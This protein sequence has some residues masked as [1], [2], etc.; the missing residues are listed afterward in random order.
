MENSSF[1]FAT[2]NKKVCISSFKRDFPKT[3][4]Q[5]IVEMANQGVIK[6]LMCYG[7]AYKVAKY[8]VS[9]GYTNVKLVDGIYNNLRGPKNQDTHRFIQYTYPDG[10]TRYY[11]PTIELIP[12]PDNKIGC[13]ICSFT[14]TAIRVF[15]IS[16]IERFS[17]ITYNEV[18]ELYQKYG[19]DLVLNYSENEQLFG[20]TLDNNVYRIYNRG[21][22]IFPRIDDNGCFVS[23]IPEFEKYIAER[24]TAA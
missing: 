11:D 4:V 8:L 14:Y 23:S 2:L 10:R 21:R 15:A 13:S 24:K 12:V 18:L 17:S 22:Y 6:E 16:E 19:I 1:E 9:K 3:I 20:S 5:G 7:N